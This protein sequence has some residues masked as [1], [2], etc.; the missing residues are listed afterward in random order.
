MTKIKSKN[1]EK[2]AERMFKIFIITAISILFLASLYG[3][4]KWIHNYFTMNDEQICG[5]S[6]STLINGQCHY[7]SNTSVNDRRNMLLIGGIGFL[8]FAVLL[9]FYLIV[10]LKYKFKEK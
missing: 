7:E 9:I 3:S 6:D 2:I 1:L 10:L 4:V 5:I 8:I